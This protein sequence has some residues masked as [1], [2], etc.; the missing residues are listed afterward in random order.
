[1][2]SQNWVGTPSTV[3][4]RRKCFERVGLFDEAIAF[5]TDYDMWI[6][7]SK[8][9]H[10]EYVQEPLI[11]Y[12]VH[13]NKMSKRSDLRI[14]GIEALLEK[15][16][17]YFASDSRNYSRRYSALGVL[18]HHQGDAQKARKALLKAVSLCPLRLSNYVNLFLSL[19]TSNN[20][21]ND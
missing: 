12:S 15:H 6:R 5:G 13:E 14:K 10:F 4:L 11:N 20:L 17:S 19:V 18:Y 16:G 3:I 7:I 1:M 9:F 21:Q 8:E 2:R